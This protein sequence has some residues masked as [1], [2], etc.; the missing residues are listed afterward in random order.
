MEVGRLLAAFEGAVCEAPQPRSSTLSTAQ[1][2]LNA[3]RC[4]GCR[5]RSVWQWS[6][7]TGGILGT[8][9][10]GEC[11]PAWAA[12]RLRAVGP[13]VGRSRHR[14]SG[15]A[16][17]RRYSGCCRRR[18]TWRA[19]RFHDTWCP[20]RRS[21]VGRVTGACR[22]HNHGKHIRPHDTSRGG[23]GIQAP[24]GTV[25]FVRCR[26]YAP[27][28]R[29]RSNS[30][31]FSPYIGKP[32][33]LSS[34]LSRFTVT[35]DAIPGRKTEQ[36]AAGGESSELV[37]GGVDCT[38]LGKWAV[39]GSLWEGSAVSV[40]GWCNIERR[41]STSSLKM[42]GPGINLFLECTRRYSDMK[43]VSSSPMS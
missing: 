32:R 42:D 41:E 16:N 11:L 20:C 8:K 33:R 14:I 9:W 35:R 36:R 6:C 28:S 23:R 1:S 17:R 10:C 29:H 40:V 31:L 24:R 3:F 12:R 43:Y 2:F 25:R 22:R 13:E 19:A 38:R 34:S 15:R 37:A 7:Q 5:W 26:T 18:S 30:T 27:F 21:S 39:T 4:S